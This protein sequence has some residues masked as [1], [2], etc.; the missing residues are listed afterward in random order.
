MSLVAVKC[1]KGT[2]RRDSNAGCCRAGG[3]SLV[4]TGESYSG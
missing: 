4:K 2:A 1:A 3:E